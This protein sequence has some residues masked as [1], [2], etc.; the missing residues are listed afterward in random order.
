MFTS[1]P[2]K[3]S[4]KCV[5]WPGVPRSLQTT[6]HHCSAC[7]VIVALRKYFSTSTEAEGPAFV[8]KAEVKEV[9]A[10][11]PLSKPETGE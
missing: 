9:V 10:T 2:F 1:F 3:K 4:T 11:P 6:V 8:A 5:I 7:P